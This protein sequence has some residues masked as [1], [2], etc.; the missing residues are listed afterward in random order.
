M[1]VMLMKGKEAFR[2]EEKSESQNSFLEHLIPQIN[3]LNNKKSSAYSTTTEIKKEDKI[4]VNTS[5]RHLST[6][7]R[8]RSNPLIIHKSTKILL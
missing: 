2:E 4:L 7:R 5:F 1:K 8:K 6:K 3:I